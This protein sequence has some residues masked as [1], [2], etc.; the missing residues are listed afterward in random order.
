VRFVSR[1]RPHTPRHDHFA[2]NIS[3]E[4][5]R[6]TIV[7]GA[8]SA[9]AGI[10]YV[11]GWVAVNARVQSYP[12]YP[13]FAATGGLVGAGT[14]WVLGFLVGTAISRGN[15][16]IGRR[17]RSI[18]SLTAIVAVACGIAISWFE[19]E[20]LPVWP[21]VVTEEEL[22]WLRP[23]TLA[24]AAIVAITLVVAS[25]LWRPDPDAA[26][27]GWNGG[28]VSV[29]A[30]LLLVLTFAVNVGYVYAQHGKHVDEWTRTCAR[31]ER[32]DEERGAWPKLIA[33][34][35]HVP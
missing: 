11:A 27:I 17:G 30:I 23:A 20:M 35:A 9:L 29:L 15:P 33:R 26:A 14:G 3:A 31:A 6:A 25:F 24:D 21:G 2:T 22:R 16:R 32:H 18:L 13:N 4:P 12:D 8:A 19:G 10:G 28:A 1:R 34:C 5:S 7:L